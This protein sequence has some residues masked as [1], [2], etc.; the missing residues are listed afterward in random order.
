MATVNWKIKGDN[1]STCNCD[2]GCPCQFNAR[3]THGFC[4]A[5]VGI[6][7]TE[8]F[9]GDVDLGGV[10]FSA[11][12]KWPGAL[13]EGNGTIQLAIDAAASQAQRE[14]LLA[15]ASGKNGGTFFEIM[16]A[17]CPNVL[18]P[19]IAPIYFASD[20]S[21]RTGEVRVEGLGAARVE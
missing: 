10:T 20:R 7:I 5:M 18:P 8:G 4:E 11:A 14:A 15:M 2:W 12:A 19:L 6:R 21:K 16:S 9:F 3:P 1:L 13:H 17:V